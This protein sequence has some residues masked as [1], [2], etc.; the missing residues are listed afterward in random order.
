[1][2]SKSK[3]ISS[4]GASDL[5]GCLKVPIGL[6]SSSGFDDNLV[7]HFNPPI[8]QYSEVQTLDFLDTNEMPQSRL[9]QI[10]STTEAT[11]PVNQDQPPVPKNELSIKFQYNF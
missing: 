7:I 6:S 5:E 8:L 9:L 11:D 4:G 3:A 2:E 1:M 10:G